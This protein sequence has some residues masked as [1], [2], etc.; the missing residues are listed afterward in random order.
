V[1]CEQRE[2]RRRQLHR[3]RL[4]SLQLHPLFAVQPQSAAARCGQRVAR[5]SQLHEQHSRTA[6]Q[7]QQLASQPSVW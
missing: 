7:P 3:Q 6:Q 4:G 2:A 5:R 1:R